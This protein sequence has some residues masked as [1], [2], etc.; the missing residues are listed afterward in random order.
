MKILPKK[1]VSINIYLAQ[2]VLKKLFLCKLHFIE[3]IPA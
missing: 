3:E 2:N 1:T